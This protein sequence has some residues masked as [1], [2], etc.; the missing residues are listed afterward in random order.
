MDFLSTLLGL[1][2][3]GVVIGATLFLFVQPN[4]E[5]Y[6]ASKWKK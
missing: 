2:I 6:Y 3:A 5:S 4:N 1:I